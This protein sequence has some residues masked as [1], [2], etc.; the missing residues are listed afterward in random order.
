MGD[1]GDEDDGGG[2]DAGGDVDMGD[3]GEAGE[4]GGGAAGGEQ[5]G[6]GAGTGGS[7]PRSSTEDTKYKKFAGETGAL[8][9]VATRLASSAAHPR[10]ALLIHGA[11]GGGWEYDLWLDAFERRGWHAVARDLEPSAAGLAATSLED[12]V[13]QVETWAPP[14]ARAE[15]LVLVGASM[16]G[17]L[18]LRAAASLRPA[19]V[20]LV[21][22]VVPRPWTRPPT[23]AERGSI[24]DVLR[25]AGSSLER[26]E[27]AMPDS[28]PEVQR[29]ACSRWRDESGAVMR[30]LRGGGYEVRKPECHTLFVISGED[31]DVLPDAQ[32]AW[33]AAWQAA[34]LELP[35]ASHVGPLLGRAAPEVAERVVEWCDSSGS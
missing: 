3:V 17:A 25:W 1:N 5:G 14:G 15:R 11:G 12:Y 22:A 2:G 32:R 27:K 10:T 8:S 7:G 24:P 34:T 13:S 18:A 21:N 9:R 23:E 30:E 26:T 29:W 35:A 20:V 16:G 19:A 33:A 31:S 28:S 6:G 4:G